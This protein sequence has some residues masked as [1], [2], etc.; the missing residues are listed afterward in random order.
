MQSKLTS[1]FVKNAIPEPRDVNV[2]DTLLPGF[3]LRIRPSGVKAWTFRYRTNGGRQQRLKLGN[4]PAVTAEEARK[5]ALIAA[6]DVANG[7]DVVARQRADRADAVRQRA[8]TLKIFLDEQY[9]PW[10]LTHLQTAAFQLKRIRSDFKDWL[11]K[12]MVRS[13]PRWLSGGELNG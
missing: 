12:P 2:T 4:Y 9:E 13:T 1:A 10:A 6:A 5:R 8:S 3:E 11:A 7:I